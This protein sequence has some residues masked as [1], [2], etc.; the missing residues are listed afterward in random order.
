MFIRCWHE[1]IPNKLKWVKCN[2]GGPFRRW[3]GNLD[4]LIDWENDG[5]RLK[6]FKDENGKPKSTLRS[7]E[8]NFK[9]AITMSRIGSGTTSFRYL[10]EGFITEGA[11]N[12]IYFEQGG[13]NLL[14]F[15]NSKSC[16]YILNLYNPTINVMP[17]DLRNLPLTYETYNLNLST[18]INECIE[19]CHI[20]WD[21]YETSWDFKKHPLI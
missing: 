18:I 13:Q 19:I 6:N 7:I 12:N 10:P 2:K 16:E 5:F 21:S 9:Q 1:I 14:A 3:Y 17:D 20:D 15:L 4:Y 11:S 8:F